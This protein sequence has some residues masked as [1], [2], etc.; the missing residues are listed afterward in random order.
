MENSIA[1][2]VIGKLQ[3]LNFDECIQLLS[4]KLAK[5]HKMLVEQSMNKTTKTK[6]YNERAY[7]FLS[8]FN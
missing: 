4:D 5:S 8:Q 2:A 1:A 7:N 3:S 6:K